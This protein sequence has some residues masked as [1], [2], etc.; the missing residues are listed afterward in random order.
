MLSI[1]SI[2][3]IR[4]EFCFI[5]FLHLLCFI[6]PFNPFLH[7]CVPPGSAVLQEF[8]ALR[9]LPGRAG[10]EEEEGR[11][12]IPQES[13]DPLLV[14]QPWSGSVDPNKLSP[15]CSHHSSPGHQQVHPAGVAPTGDEEASSSSPLEP[16]LQE[17]LSPAGCRDVSRRT[18]RFAL[19]CSEPL[20]KFPC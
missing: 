15:R 10:S 1:I 13:A 6:V 16:A 18:C 12:S 4:R 9:G 11:Q 19:V 3:P 14:T 2:A 5:S 8:R 7:G 17:Q 20:T